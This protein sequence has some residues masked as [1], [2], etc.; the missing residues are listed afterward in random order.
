MNQDEMKVEIN[1]KI[2]Q[3]WNKMVKD[4][5]QITT[6]NSEMWEDLLNFCLSEFLTKKSVE[7][8]YKVAVI[9]DK[10]PNYIGR[11][12]SLNIKSNTSPFWTTYRRDSYN[13]RGTY[14]AEVLENKELYHTQEDT[15]GLELH[16]ID[17]YSCV[18][19]H[20]EKLNFYDKQIINHYL[21]QEWTYKQISE[22]YNIPI[23]GITKDIKRIM[24]HLKDNC[25]E[26][27]K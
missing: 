21:I 8:Q 10:L 23:G 9:D 26:L 16:Q 7:Y 6:Y 25:H 11:S 18:M 19:Y 17:P 4:H 14:E 2:S 24:K 22:Y 27:Y 20:I 13:F 15:I 1:K 3:H 5:K 12:M